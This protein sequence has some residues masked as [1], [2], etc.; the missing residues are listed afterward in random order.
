MLTPCF[1]FV[2]AD[3]WAR[4]RSQELAH[5]ASACTDLEYRFSFGWDELWGIANRGDYDLKCHSEASG[6][7]LRYTD[8]VTR[9]VCIAV[10]HTMAPL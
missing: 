10:L 7:N 3:T 8:P 2:I 5:Y 9:E 6:I 1:C 4:R